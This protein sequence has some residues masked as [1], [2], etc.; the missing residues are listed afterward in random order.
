MSADVR[1]ANGSACQDYI[2][3]RR[4]DGGALVLGTLWVGSPIRTGPVHDAY[5]ARFILEAQ[6][7][8]LYSSKHCGEE[9]ER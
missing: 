4:T 2:P 1:T 7:R 5:R 8:G 9:A 6:T 3:T